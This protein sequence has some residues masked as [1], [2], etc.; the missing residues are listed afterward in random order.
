M[1]IFSFQKTADGFH[2][3]ENNCFKNIKNNFSTSHFC[4]CLFIAQSRYL[5]V[6]NDIIVV[7]GRCQ[8]PKSNVFKVLNEFTGFDTVFFAR[9]VNRIDFCLYLT[10]FSL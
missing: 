3:F 5:E 10:F 7:K 8:C 9:K 2:D 1:S 6:R 4:S